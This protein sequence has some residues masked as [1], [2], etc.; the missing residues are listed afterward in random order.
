MNARSKFQI[1]MTGRRPGLTEII[2]VRSKWG[3]ASSRVGASFESKSRTTS[4]DV[5]ISG[6]HNANDCLPREVDHM[7]E[8]SIAIV[9]ASDIDSDSLATLHA[10]D[11]A[12]L[13][14]SLLLTKRPADLEEEEVTSGSSSGTFGSSPPRS[15]KP[16][17]QTDK[18]RRA[19]PFSSSPVL[20]PASSS[21]VPQLKKRKLFQS[22]NQSP[23][24]KK[25][26]IV[27]GF[28]EDDE[29]EATDDYGLLKEK[30]APVNILQPDQ[31]ILDIDDVLDQVN[32]EDLPEP[33]LPRV[34]SHPTPSHSTTGLCAETSTGT[35]FR[36]ALRP[37]AQKQTYEEIIAQRSVTAAGRA[38][39]AYYG[40][41]I[42][43]LMHDANLQKELD[44]SQKEVEEQKALRQMEERPVSRQSESSV[45]SS[46]GKEHQMWTE[47]YRAKK[48]TDLV[49]D[50]RTHRSV[51]KWLKGWDQI[52]FGSSKPRAKRIFEDQT[53]G[54]RQ[55]RKILLLTGPPGLGKTTLAHVCARK[56]G[57]ET[58][59]INAS[60]DRSRDVVK[61]RIKDVLG[62]ETVRGIKEAGKERRAGRPVCVVVDEVDGV[63]TGSGGSGEG[64]F[65]KALIDLMHIDQHNS[66]NVGKQV[67]GSRKKKGDSFRMLRPLILVCNDVYAPSL[68]PLRTSSLAEIVHVRKPALDK[69][70]TR[71]RTVFDSESILC[72]NDAVR[73]ICES[74]WGM[75]SRK[76][77]SLG[78]RGAGEGDLRGILVQ[79]EWMAHKFR[80]KTSTD[81]ASQ[82]RLT[83]KWVESQ[84][85][86]SQ[87]A[88]GN[89]GLGRGGTREVIDRIFIEGAGLPNLPTALSA[90]E[91]RMVDE[92]KTTS[93]GVADIRKRAAINALRQM[94]D[95]CGEHDRLMTECFATYP[96]QVFQDDTQLSKP[97]A[98]YDWLH[99]HDSLSRKLYGQQEW[100]LGA[101]M[102]TGACAFHHL[103][104]SVDKGNKT[105]NDEKK[106]DEDTVAHPYSG[107]RADFAAYEAEKETKTILTELQASFSAPLLRL[108]SSIDNMATELI[109][110][111]NRMLAPDVKPVVI[112]GG[113]GAASV[114]SVRKESEK[115]CVQ[116]VVRVMNGLNLKFDKHKVEI[117]AS[118]G[119]ANRATFVY[120]MEP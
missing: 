110:S 103:F 87:S 43:T 8:G 11:A 73:R 69:V 82:P 100:E 74:A 18:A 1:H 47:K 114:A 112:G 101:Y 13:K 120:R 93:I 109:P 92:S 81:Q 26:K 95:T 52:V 29:D 62:T 40:I 113:G 50:E 2:P 35:P 7:E 119:P 39:R 61:G 20:Y 75:G 23:A 30:T 80:R 27:E 83:R 10:E 25:A 90:D 56:A 98:A 37:A 65:M 77:N 19:M 33:D 45:N 102:N 41:E 24:A 85:G 21:P 89:K 88:S 46:K 49:G 58:L 68:R 84:M 76:Q 5:D 96:A 53:D 38:K 42:Q 64:G 4:S 115:A 70:I 6:R 99:F 91:A 9:S 14:K 15:A 108:F 59:E 111:V 79:A 31:D 66:N 44:K 116:N 118:A 86:D 51:L 48:F 94:V 72:D 117:D 34:P 97:T 54:E 55:H 105:W 22:L 104:A 67:A 12:G 16:T 107:P 17:E 3:N 60:D 28:V 106:E 57:Y 36:I 78:G 63:T 71:L 32:S